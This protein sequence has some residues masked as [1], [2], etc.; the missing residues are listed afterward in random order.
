M[1]IIL[2]ST[3]PRRKMLLEQL[4]LQFTVMPSMA[5]EEIDPQLSP[6]ELVV[7]L[8]YQKARA[9]ADK[10]PGGYL[11]IG[12]DTIVVLDN[13]ILGKPKDPEEVEETLTRLSGKSHQV[14]TGVT[15]IR[16]KDQMIRKHC[17]VTQ[18]KFRPLGKEEIVNY[19]QSKE[20]LD[21]AGAY[22]I[23]GKGAIFVEKIEG[24]YFNVVG[25]PLQKLTSIL[26]DLG[27]RVL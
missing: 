12:A 21:K 24:C 15:V 27:L 19:I 2:A 18:V 14:M 17:E 23:Q 6:Q 7:Q 26:S 13:Q 3:S 8:S 10:F 16:T 1:Q 9:V 22:G 4:G 5:A 11:V 20:P 25:L